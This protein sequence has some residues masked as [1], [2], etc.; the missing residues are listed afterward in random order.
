MSYSTKARRGLE[1]ARDLYKN[2]DREHRALTDAE[3]AEV[4]SALD[5]AEREHEIKGLAAPFDGF[6]AGPAGG[7]PG[8]RFIASEGYKAISDPALRG[9]QWSTGAVEVGMMAKGTL[10]EGAGAPGSGT[11]GGLLQVPQVVP[12]VV[13]T[14]FQRLTV[15]DLLASAMAT[16]N[17]VRVTVEGTATSGAA[18]VAEGAVKPESTLGLSTV[19]EPVKKI[20]TS[21]T[22]S[23]ELLEDAPATQQ[24]VGRRL[25]LFVDVELDR[26]LLRGGGTNELVGITGRSGVSTWGRGTVDSNAVALFKAM[27][28]QRGSSFLE[29]SA[30][31]MHPTN[32]QTTRL[33]T[34]S[35]GQFFGGGPFLGPYGGP[36]GP[37]GIGNQVTG[38][39]D[40]IW[41]KPV[42][43]STVIGA[44]TAL[45]G[46]FD[47]AA[48]LYRRGGMTVEA[49][50][51]HSDYFE[52]N[53]VKI[54]AEQRAAL[55]VLRPPRS[56]W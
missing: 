47:A 18:G 50:N 22:T 43:L 5:A 10:L 16:T 20:A 27:T 13:E 1:H 30:I 37:V 36:Q 26:Q 38:E 17:T 45:V 44:G 25:S 40:R 23:D 48:T 9:Q 24:F 11:G 46:A 14:L 41:G 52:K 6:F 32:W 39:V 2:A 28:G 56:R 7:D 49:S 12:G 19:D 34:D 29:P 53:L 55:A 3:V 15:A 8:S 21:L 42:V 4:E 54:R 33:G 51:S 35:A 31:I